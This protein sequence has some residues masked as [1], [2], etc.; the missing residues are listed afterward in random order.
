MRPWKEKN[1]L[2]RNSHVNL[3]NFPVT[4]FRTVPKSRR[5]RSLWHQRLYAD[6]LLQKLHLSRLLPWF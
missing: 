4:C 6:H 3:N 1:K 5:N 2:S